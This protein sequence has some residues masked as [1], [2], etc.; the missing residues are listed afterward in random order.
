MKN[1]V[2]GAIMGAIVG[3]A[4]GLPFEFKSKGEIKKQDIRKL[5]TRGYHNQPI[6]AWSDDSSMILCTMESMLNG[7]SYM[8]I[9][10]K[11]CEWKYKAHWTPYGILFDIGDTTAKAIMNINLRKDYSG[12]SEENNCGNGSLMRIIPILFYIK[13]NRNERFDIIKEVSS[14]THSN[15]ICVI[16]CS[17]YLEMCLNILDGYD[18]KVAYTKMKAT[19]IDY[20][21]EYDLELKS[22][23]NILYKDIL[24]INKDELSG[25]GYVIHTLE[26]A[27][28]SFLSTKNFK[29]AIY[30]AILLGDDTDTVASITGGI[31]GL[32]YGYNKIPKKWKNLIVKKEEIYNLTDMFYLKYK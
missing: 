32:Y 14:L 16:A 15:M 1:N 31:S 27:L 10:D 3:D 17:I 18:K 30:N 11:F 12:L 8:N 4:I 28:Y 20:Y 5:K 9:G 6:G 22:F 26:S 24:D 13:D 25:S 2:Y 19:I 7:Y 23:H 29:Q 21:K